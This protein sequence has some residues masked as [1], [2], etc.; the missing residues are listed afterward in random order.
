MTR[1]RWLLAGA[2]FAL[3]LGAGARPVAAQTRADSAAVLLEGARLLRAQGQDAAADALL[4]LIRQRFTD[5]SAA[6]EAGRMLLGRRGTP[7]VQRSGRVELLVFGTTYGLWL[8]VALPIMAQADGPEAYGAGLLLGGPAGFLA[9]RR[10]LANRPVSEGQARAITFGGTWGT[11]QGFGWTEVLDPGGEECEPSPDGYCYEPTTPTAEARVA[12][13]VIGGLTGIA[14][15]AVLARKP[16][17]SG[18]ATAVSFGALWGTWYGF[19]LGTLAD[20]EDD[21][22]LGYTLAGGDVGLL[23]VAL[24]APRW[25]VSR[26]RARLVSLGGV[27]GL[28]G[29]LGI[30]LLAV[31]DNEDVAILIPT[32]TSALGLGLAARA[33]RSMDTDNRGESRDGE[34]GF[35]GALLEYRPG[36]WRVE[37]PAVTMKLERAAGRA[38][39]TSLYVPLVSARF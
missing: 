25:N 38:G 7:E 19:A 6:D 13:A 32:V 2:L 5:T 21:E 16:I 34:A 30:D 3:A 14:T 27:V 11:W 37:V 33:T 10:Y 36:G 12:G 17:A 15:G 1:M 26:S 22:L 24:L 20:A 28:L 18:T 9:A 23:T 35:S 39:A 31:R 8:G 29:G 4:Q